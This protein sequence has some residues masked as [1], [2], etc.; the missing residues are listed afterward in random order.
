MFRNRF[1]RGGSPGRAASFGLS[2]AGQETRHPGC[3]TASQRAAGS[4]MQFRLPGDDGIHQE[5]APP[6][7]QCR[8]KRRASVKVLASDVERA[9]P[10]VLDVVQSGL[11]PQTAK[12]KGASP[13][14]TVRNV[15]VTSR[16]GC[17]GRRSR[18][19]G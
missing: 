9:F 14:G 11:D 8:P 3:E 18:P 12:L 7:V 4:E 19:P 2:V 15:P 6:A 10:L 17:P 13:P 16:S 5:P 1:G